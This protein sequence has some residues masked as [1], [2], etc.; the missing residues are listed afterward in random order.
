MTAN[1][2]ISVSPVPID[3]S[4]CNWTGYQRGSAYSASDRALLVK[5]RQVDAPVAL[6][7]TRM[8]AGNVFQIFKY[9]FN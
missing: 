3:T 9:L 6:K 1:Q 4:T 2:I 5:T 8:K 7:G